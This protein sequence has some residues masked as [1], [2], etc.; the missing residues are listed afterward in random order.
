MRLLWRAAPHPHY[1]ISFIIPSVLLLFSGAFFAFSLSS[2]TG[3]AGWAVLAG[4]VTQ[5]PVLT[6]CIYLLHWA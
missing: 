1:K 6:P 4:A 5:V 3:A 2:A